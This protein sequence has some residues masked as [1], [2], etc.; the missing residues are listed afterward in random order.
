MLSRMQTECRQYMSPEGHVLVPAACL[1]KIGEK[2]VYKIQTPNT[3]IHEPCN[4]TGSV[5]LLL[6]LL[7]LLQGDQLKVNTEPAFF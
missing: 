5:S 7:H 1:H 4:V 3:K 2:I 6:K